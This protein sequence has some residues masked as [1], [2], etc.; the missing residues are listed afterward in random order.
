MDED[1]TGGRCKISTCTLYENDTWKTI[2]KPYTY[3]IYRCLYSSLPEKTFAEKILKLRKLNNLEK[4]EL[5]KILDL[6]L[7]TILKWEVDEI[8]PKPKN[9]KNICDKFNLSLSYF[10][11][12]YFTYY[13]SPGEKIRQWKDKNNYTYTQCSNILNISYSCF[14]RLLSGK[15]NLS[16]HIY[17]KLK[18]VGAL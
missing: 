13:N 16:Y 10:G 15:I 3:N 2:F 8:E 9:I 18:E 4:L 6:H 5:A 7:D 12:Y 14:E 17:M 11:D 1:P